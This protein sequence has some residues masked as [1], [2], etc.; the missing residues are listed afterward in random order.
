MQAS[1]A[2]IRK[3]IQNVRLRLCYIIGNPVNAV[4]LPFL[5]PLFFYLLKVVFHLSYPS[6]NIRINIFLPN[7]GWPLEG[8]MGKSGDQ[9]YGITVLWYCGGIQ[10]SLHSQY[11]L[12]NAQ[13]SQSMN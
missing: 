13:Y 2:W 10:I 8:W 7:P 6:L 11:R 1:A 9:E 3:H 12:P 5:L 4:L